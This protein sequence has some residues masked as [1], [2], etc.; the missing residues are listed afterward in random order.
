MIVQKDGEQFIVTTTNKAIDV[1]LYFPKLDTNGSRL[2][3]AIQKIESEGSMRDKGLELIQK[4][5]E[6]AFP[7]WGNIEIL[8]E[9]KLKNSDSTRHKS[10]SGEAHPKILGEC[11]V[12][13]SNPINCT[14]FQTLTGEAFREDKL[15]EAYQ[16]EQREL[17]KGLAEKEV[18]KKLEIRPEDIWNATKKEGIKKSI[19]SYES[20]KG[21]DKFKPFTGKKETEG[22]S[23]YSEINL[24][25]L[26]LM[27]ERFQAN[28]GKY[29][30]GNSKKPLDKQQILWA[31]FRHVKK[32]VQP[33]EDDEESFKEHLAATLT[34]CSII[35]DQ[36]ELEK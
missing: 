19:D 8:D 17:N 14:W 23:D 3:S 30:H 21:N 2:D 7:N 29:E 33:I 16:K 18:F 31:L 12:F 32:M 9:Q 1:I 5:R 35:L 4:A 25:I 27:A 6:V 20:F 22:K 11:V 13:N 10:Q 15:S 28:K 24:G 26:D 34:N 36:L